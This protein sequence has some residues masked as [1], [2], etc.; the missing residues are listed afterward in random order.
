M[1]LRV[2]LKTA[3]SV[4]IETI[5]EQIYEFDTPG[6][7]FV[8]G[9]SH[10]ETKKTVFTLFDLKPDMD[11]NICLERDGKKAEVF[12]RTDYEFVTL[13]VREIGAKGDGIQMILHLSRLRLWHVRRMEEYLFQKV[14]TTLPACF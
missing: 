14:P 12:F 7:I 5:T 9:E 11:Y 1:K 13:D 10:G 2:A 6:T 8:N 4:T 3:R